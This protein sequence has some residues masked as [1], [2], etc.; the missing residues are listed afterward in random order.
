MRTSTVFVGLPALCFLLT[1]FPPALRG[2]AVHYVTPGSA[3]SASG[4]F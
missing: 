2:Q 3:G 4:D 1:L